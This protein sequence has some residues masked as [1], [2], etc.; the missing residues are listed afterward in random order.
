MPKAALISAKAFCVHHHIEY[1]FI[2]N[3]HRFGLV[4]II[5]GEDGFFIPSKHVSELE[6]FI[7]LYR[8]L[9]INP[10]GIDAIIHLLNRLEIMQKKINTLQNRLSFY[11]PTG[12]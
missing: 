1:S 5:S 4:E 7:R 9:E 2:Q 10:E 3:L 8:D 12:K 11:E 6:R